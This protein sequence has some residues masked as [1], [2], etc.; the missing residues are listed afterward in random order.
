LPIEKLSPV[1]PIRGRDTDSEPTPTPTPTPT[2]EDV[3]VVVPKLVGRTIK[4]AAA[5]AN[6]VLSVGDVTVV[7]NPDEAG[8]VVEQKP[9]AG[10]KVSSSSSI[11]LLVAGGDPSIDAATARTMIR[12]D[13]RVVA[14][15]IAA[16][17][18]TNIEKKL[19]LD[20]LNGLQAMTKLSAEEI[21]KVLPDENLDSAKTLQTVAVDVAAK[22]ERM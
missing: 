6:K 15:K 1:I 10:D 14:L 18:M 12:L 11:A 3:L 7:K 21:T 17:T 8:K 19:E 2:P 4:N 20:T 16:S 9:E 5:A 22:F 13:S